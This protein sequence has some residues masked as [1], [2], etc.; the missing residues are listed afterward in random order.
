MM[1]YN[2]LFLYGALWF[3]ARSL[4]KWPRQE[5]AHVK[6][7]IKIFKTSRVRKMSV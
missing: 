3:E 1:T 2:H 7:V 4:G 5:E 6:L